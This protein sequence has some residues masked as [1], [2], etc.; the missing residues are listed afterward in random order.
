[1]LVSCED[2]S[3]KKTPPL[4]NCDFINTGNITFSEMKLKYAIG[5][6]TPLF[7]Q[8]HDY[9]NMGYIDDFSNVLDDAFNSNASDKDADISLTMTG[10]GCDGASQVSYTK[11]N[12]G[13]YSFNTLSNTPYSAGS[14]EVKLELIIKSAVYNDKRCFWTMIFTDNI[15]SNTSNIQTGSIDGVWKDKDASARIGK[16]TRVYVYDKFNNYIFTL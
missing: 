1:M 11:A 16:S 7:K 12:S 15:G 10:V 6:P 2:P 5:M 8:D 14:Y 13:L 4:D 9:S 3:N